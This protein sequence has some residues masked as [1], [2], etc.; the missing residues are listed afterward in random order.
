M[1]KRKPEGWFMLEAPL[2]VWGRSASAEEGLRLLAERLG[3][4]EAQRIV[5]ADETGVVYPRSQE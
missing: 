5:E 4:K 2:G 1:I 3:R